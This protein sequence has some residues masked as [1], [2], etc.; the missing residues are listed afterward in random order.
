VCLGDLTCLSNLCVSV[1]SDDTTSAA[2]VDTGDEESSG[3]QDDD[4]SS[5]GALSVGEDTG[6]TTS[7]DAETSSGGEESSTT[8]PEPE[9]LEGD[10]Y[11]AEAEHQTCVDGQ[12]VTSTCEENCNLVGYHST[13]CESADACLCD[14]FAND[15]CFN[16]AAGYCLCDTFNGCDDPWLYELY[17]FCI[18]GEPILD[19][20]ATFLD[21]DTYD[22]DCAAAEAACL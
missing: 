2:P 13:G 1:P 6:E 21:P 18:A 5:S 7:D 17:D 15:A 22:I 19:C 14:G 16:G 11:C 9:C 10:N 20:Y 8:E 3:A 12:W 4:E